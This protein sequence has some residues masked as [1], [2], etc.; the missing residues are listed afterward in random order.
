M[1]NLFRFIIK[2]H[3]FILF[4]II[5]SFSLFL[6]IQNNT[7]Q[8]ASFIN[9]SNQ[10]TGYIYSAYHS[11]AEYLLLKTANN[12]LARENAYLR[13]VIKRSIKTDK[14]YWNV[15]RDSVKNRHYHYTP[16]KVINNS[17]NRQNNY[18]TLNKGANQGI[19]PEMGV[20]SP[21]GV[22]G[23]VRNVSGNF[24]SVISL[25]N[26]SLSISAKIKKN[27]YYGSLV[28]DGRDNTIVSL[29]EIPYHVRISAGD[30][31]VTSGYSAIFPEGLPIGVINDYELKKG[32]NFYYIS[33]RLLNDF[34]HLSYVYVIE[35]L[36]KEERKELERTAGND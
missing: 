30:T 32:A 25:L 29:K 1:R 26:N 33:V 20:V 18:I 5:E 15:V 36:F 27:G 24:S 9:S 10:I 2:F 12:D 14:E 4:I 21:N 28:W 8:K 13:N 6:F 17:V 23:I 11:M 3:F 19:E 35:N 22:V 16:A 34:R 31:V 7:Y